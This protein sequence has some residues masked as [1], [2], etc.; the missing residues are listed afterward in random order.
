MIL[1]EL[2][3]DTV[4]GKLEGILGEIDHVVQFQNVS[5]NKWQVN[6][7]F[8]LDQTQLTDTEKAL[9]TALFKHL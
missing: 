9:L 1:E 3:K 6:I 4:M 5:A 2:V 8:D 7:V